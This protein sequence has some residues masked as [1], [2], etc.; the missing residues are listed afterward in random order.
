MKSDIRKD[1]LDF[2]KSKSYTPL[3]LPQIATALGLSR[4]ACAPLRKAMDSLIADGTA[5]KVKGD[6]YG[7][8][9]D[10]NLLAG[11][12]AFRQRGGAFLDVP[13]SD[14]RIEIRPEDTGVALNSDKVLARLLP[15]SFKPRRGRNGRRD[16]N[17]AN[18]GVRYAKVIRI[19]ER[20]NSK[21]VGTLR[22]SYSFWHVVPDDPKFFYDVIVADPAKSGVVPPPKENDKVVVR[23]NEWVQKHMNPTGEIVENLGESHT[24]MAEYRSILVKYDLSETFPE[25]VEKCADSVPC[26]VS[27]RD[28]SGRFDARSIPTITIDPEDAKDFDDAIS[29][30][31]AEGGNYEVGV[32]IAD[33]SKYVKPSSPLDR[34]AAKRGN[35]TYLVGTVIP[36]LPFKLSNG[37]CSLVEDEDRLVKSVFLT[38]SPNGNILGAHFANS[39]IR[40][41][42]RLSYEQ[43]HALITLDNLGEAAAVRPPENYETAFSGKDLTELSPESLAALQKMVRTLWGIASGMRQRRMKEGSLDLNMPEFKIFCDKDGYADRIEKIEYNESHQLVEEFML[44]ANREVSKALFGAKI[45]YISRVHDEPDPDQLSE[46][47]DELE[48]FGIEC[49]DLTSRRE[50][51]KLLEQINAHPQAYILKT[52]FLRSLKR[53]EYRASPDGHYGLYMRFYAHF[54]SPIRRYADLTVHRCFDR[55]LWERKIPTAPKYAPAVLAKTELEAVAEA[56]TRTEGNSTEAERESHKIKLMEYFERRIG[57]GNAFEAIVTSL[58]NHGF[59]VDLTQSQAYGFVHLRTL[60]DDIYHLSDD[61]TELRGRRT[62]T[63][64]R[65][66]DKV[67][68]DVE[69]VDRFKRQIDFRLADCAQPLNE[70]GESGFAGAKIADARKSKNKSYK[71]FGGRRE[72]GGRKGGRKGGGKGGKRRR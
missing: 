50:I 49:G 46:L 61:G 3:T 67:Y 72:K 62:G 6:R 5:A 7:L 47:R 52:M 37:I 22:R 21:V 43:A 63:T 27:A 36:M 40:S 14:E 30:R 10:L 35:S 9:G 28:I 45:P 26:E 19:L 13:G 17:A 31:P 1:L 41:S 68:V 29:L 38:V 39:V 71:E 51:I 34:E 59:F 70:R 4:K 2:M 24:P 53:A 66:G 18:Y 11:T 65:A 64:F 60:H 54:T 23:L 42:K 33:V 8:S 15:E 55:M 16:W 69:S 20:A 57:K 58:S 32:H 56:I 48:P 44:A 12:I 25:D